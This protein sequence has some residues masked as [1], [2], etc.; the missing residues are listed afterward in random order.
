M[1]IKTKENTIYNRT[2]QQFICDSDADMDELKN[3]TPKPPMGSIAFV[4]ESGKFW[5][6]KSDGEWNEI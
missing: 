3:L 2:V 5:M 4:I 1:F 6:I